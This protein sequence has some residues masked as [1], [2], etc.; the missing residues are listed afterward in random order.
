[1]RT[2]ACRC[3]PSE[4]RAEQMVAIVFRQRK[5]LRGII[6]WQISCADLG[7]SD[8][9]RAPLMPP[10]PGTARVR[11]VLAEARRRAAAP[12]TGSSAIRA[13]PTVAWLDRVFRVGEVNRLPRHHSRGNVEANLHDCHD[14]DIA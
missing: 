13:T 1:V 6:K 4:A 14:V 8:K 2:L 3:A 12:S 5:L 7:I 9:A 11:P 10:R